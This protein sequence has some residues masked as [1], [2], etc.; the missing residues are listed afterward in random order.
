MPL[1]WDEAQDDQG[2]TYYFHRETHEVSWH[3]P[4]AQVL[5]S[6]KVCPM[7]GKVFDEKGRT[8]FANKETGQSSWSGPKQTLRQANRLPF[9]EKEMVAKETSHS[10]APTFK[11]EK[12]LPSKWKATEHGDGSI[13][14][15][16]GRLVHVSWIKEQRSA[17]AV[18]NMIQHYKTRISSLN[19]AL[20]FKKNTVP[21]NKLFY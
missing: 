7:V 6:M 3:R 16:H 19:I 1:G 18:S 5:T 14:F 2:R 9:K 11:P 13:I 20:Y 12:D 17:F 10:K 4:T 21:M 8:Y 15:V